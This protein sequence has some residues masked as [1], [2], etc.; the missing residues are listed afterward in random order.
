MTRIFTPAGVLFAVAL[1]MLIA[2]GTNLDAGRIATAVV[3]GIG[4]FVCLV[5]ACVKE[6]ERARF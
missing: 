2:C 1:V 6:S 5:V 4:A 3:S